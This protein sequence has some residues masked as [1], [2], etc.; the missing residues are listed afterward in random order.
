MFGKRKIAL[1]A[2]IW[3]R[4]QRC[5]RVAGY[6]STEEFVLHVIEKELAQLEDATDD[7]DLRNKLRGLGYIE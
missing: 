5:A 4:V 3:E 6:A 2:D 7:D 1:D